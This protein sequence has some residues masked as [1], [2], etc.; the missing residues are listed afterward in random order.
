MGNQNTLRFIMMLAIIAFSIFAVTLGM[1]VYNRTE[2]KVKEVVDESIIGSY[3]SLYKSYEGNQAGYNIKQLLIKVSNNNQVIYNKEKT[4]EGCV[5]IRSNSTKI[6]NK[7]YDDRTIKELD[8]RA[9]YGVRYPES[10]MEL[11]CLVSG[12]SQFRVSFTY[13][14]KTKSIGEIWIDD[15]S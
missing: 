11:V 14:R 2:D 5:A 3:D 13:N 6:L 1:I 9:S 7:I 15:I 8:G 10:I 12:K 4:M